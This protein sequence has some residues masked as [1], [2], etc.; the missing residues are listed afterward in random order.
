MIRKLSL[1]VLVSLALGILLSACGTTAAPSGA[2]DKVTLQLKW[3]AQ[4]QFAG[5][6]AAKE[7]GYYDAENLDVTIR[8]GGP[9]II[10]EQVVA[11]G[12]AQFGL[13]WL[14]SLLSSR[15]SGSPLVNVAQV[16]QKSGMLSI[17]WKDTS[18]KGV[19][20]YKGKK[21]AVWLGGNEFEL[22]A[23]L[24]KYSL[25]PKKDL[26]IVSQPFDMNLL[27]DRKVVAAAAMTYN[28]YAQVLEVKNPATGKLYQ[29]DDLEIV[30]FNKEGTAMLQ[31]GIFATEAFLKDAKNQDITTRFLKASFKGWMFC[32]DNVQECVDIVLK[33]GPT[34]PKGHQTWQMNEI[35]KLTWPSPN[36]VGIMD[37][38]LY[39][40]TSDIAAK[41]GVI[42]KAAGKEA[43]TTDYA[44]KA[45][46]ALKGSD[47]TGANYKPIAVTLTEGG[48]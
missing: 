48:K 9:D 19:P 10:P 22:Y 44:K 25:D 34:L 12:Q 41:Y 31:D 17:R 8:P 43:Y 38:K 16:F 46:D 24:A 32:R 20:D 39:S 5:Y 28:E 27:L 29:P 11:S 6:Y 18:L 23:T 40:Q 26:E 7:K 42:K 33:Q 14:P 4:A 1:L 47:T 13:D 3:V 36:G 35:N 15:E 2:K 45:L 30:D 21:V 37:D